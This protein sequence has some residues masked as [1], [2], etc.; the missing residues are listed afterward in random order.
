MTE[1]EA[2]TK[3]AELS[4]ND[5]DR[6]THSWVPRE[7]ADG[8]SIAKLAVP[9][10]GTQVRIATTSEEEEAIKNDPRPANVRN[11][12]PGGMGM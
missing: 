11:V 8:W 6:F 10:P 7:G 4:K 3:C 1:E 9:S 2:K 12:G 5:P